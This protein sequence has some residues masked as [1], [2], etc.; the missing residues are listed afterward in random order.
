MIANEPQ[1][2]W[3]DIPATIHCFPAGFDTSVV[4][5][6]EI[7]RDGLNDIPFRCGLF[8]VKKCVL[9]LH[10]SPLYDCS[11]LTKEFHNIDDQYHCNITVSKEAPDPRSF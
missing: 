9:F 1:R 6:E 10:S 5:Y 3:G 4:L 7:A 8:V 11:K 2:R